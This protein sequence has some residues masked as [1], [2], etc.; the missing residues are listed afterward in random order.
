MRRKDVAESEDIFEI[1]ATY[2]WSLYPPVG[3]G[4]LAGGS[5]GNAEFKE[6]TCSHGIKH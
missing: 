4:A 5:F 2:G 6:G 3:G 1:V